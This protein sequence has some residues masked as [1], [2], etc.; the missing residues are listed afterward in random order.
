M[1]NV[2][3]LGAVV[4]GGMHHG[5]CRRDSIDLRDNATG[6]TRLK[7][8]S[9]PISARP[10]LSRAVS[11]SSSSWTHGSALDLPNRLWVTSGRAAIVL[12]L[13][14]AGLKAGDEVLVPAYACQSMVA[15]ITHLGLIPRFYGLDS[16]L[17]VDSFELGSRRTERTK[18]LLLTRYHGFPSEKGN[19]VEYC[20]RNGIL[21]I[22]DRAH[23]FF[24]QPDPGSDYVIYSLAK[25][26][27]V[28][29]GGLLA[30]HRRDVGRIPIRPPPL[31][32]QVASALWPFEYAARFEPSILER[33][34][35]SALV[36]AKRTLKLGLFRKST[37]EAQPRLVPAAAEGG[38][39]LEPSWI[40][41]SITL[42]SRIAVVRASLGS[43]AEKRRHNWQRLVGNLQASSRGLSLIHRELRE[44]TVPYAA[45]LTVADPEGVSRKLKERQIPLYRWDSFGVSTSEESLRETADLSFR[46]LQ[47]PTHQAMDDADIDRIS[48]AILDASS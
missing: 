17:C 37:S 35:A 48:S 8:D 36:K 3:L 12:A 21:V 47:I 45:A 41:K 11:S 29:E 28:F 23:A 9:R 16:A 2:A 32:F 15:P 24:G 1:G 25:F 7:A 46:V 40:D 27:P 13:Q 38:A 4:P 39:D 26:F 33:G 44:T 18:A 31:S 10:R 14:H 34:L 30:S 43:I 20:S 6:P 22:E 42:A 5:R 19:V